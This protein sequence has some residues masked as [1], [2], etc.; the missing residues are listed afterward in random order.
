MNEWLQKFLQRNLEISRRKAVELIKKGAIK[1]NSVPIKDLGIKVTEDDI[2]EYK[3]ERVINKSHKFI[4]IILNKPKRSIT[5]LSDTSG[6]RT[7]IDI[8]DKK[9]KERIF[10][11]GRL[12]YMTTGLLILTNDGDFYQSLIHPRFSKEK[13][14]R[15]LVTGKISEKDIELFSDMIIDGKRV[16][17]SRLKILREFKDNSLVEVTIFQG[18]NR[19]IRKMF[20]LMDKK[21]LYL[22]RIKLG[23]FVLDKNL[24]EGE[25]RFF[26]SK[27]MDIVK[28]LKYEMENYIKRT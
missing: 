14:Y 18:L 11:V 17:G 2:V 9:I 23:P 7:V 8:L 24:K 22:K 4:Y 21:V 10:P 3:E 15:V 19:Q 28:R 27:E 13:V 1:V 25:W 12:D 5:S 6:R 26:N 16:V 20:E